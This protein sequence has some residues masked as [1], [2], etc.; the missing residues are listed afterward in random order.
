MHS[1]I[2][3]ELVERLLGCIDSL[4]PRGLSMTAYSAAKLLFGDYRRAETYVR[5]PKN[6]GW[7]VK[8][9]FL[10]SKWWKRCKIARNT[11]VFFKIASTKTIQNV[12]CDPLCGRTPIIKKK[13]N[14]WRY[15]FL[16]SWLLEKRWYPQIILQIFFT[17]KPMVLPFISH[18]SLGFGLSWVLQV[19]VV[20]NALVPQMLQKPPGP[21][22][23]TLVWY[24]CGAVWVMD[25]CASKWWK[26]NLI[27]W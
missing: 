8:V 4:E 15:S 22:L 5:D 6:K 14:S 3:L 27:G 2:F 25:G 9:G 24:E 7:L 16:L 11:L 1:E 19:V 18:L 20:V 12:L 21:L 17:E 10:V 13:R 26:P 23:S